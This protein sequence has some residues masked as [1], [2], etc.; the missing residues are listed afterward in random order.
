MF[1]IRPNEI[2]RNGHEPDGRNQL[3]ARCDGEQDAS[4]MPHPRKTHRRQQWEAVFNIFGTAQRHVARYAT[5]NLVSSGTT[6]AK[7]PSVRRSA[8]PASRPARSV[9]AS[10]CIDSTPDNGYGGEAA[11]MSRRSGFPSREFGQ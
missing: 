1:A 8:R 10:G 5:E 6:P 2:E 4:V 3:W 11:A 7:P 9:I